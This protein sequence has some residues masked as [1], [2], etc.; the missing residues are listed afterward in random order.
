M[1][2]LALALVVAGGCSS[3][4][5]S[6]Q[7]APPFRP[8]LGWRTDLGEFRVHR[9]VALADGSLV[10]GATLHD[11]AYR[12]HP[13]W[14]P[15]DKQ[16]SGFEVI[17]PDGVVRR[18]FRIDGTSLVALG[19]VGERVV[20][21]VRRI[22]EVD[23]KTM[24]A[25]YTVSRV[26][27]DPIAGRAGAEQ[28]LLTTNDVADISI[29]P[30]GDGFAIVTS[31][32]GGKT[33]TV[34]RDAP[35]GKQRW[36]RTLDGEVTRVEDAG[37]GTLATFARSKTAIVTR[38]L[39]ARGADLRSYELGTPD[40]GGGY[41]A[42]FERAVRDDQELVMF[43][44]VGGG[45]ELAGKKLARAG[46]SAQPFALHTSAVAP[47]RFF[48]VNRGNGFVIGAGRWLGRTILALWI[49]ASP[50]DT[51]TLPW[52]IYLMAWD[53]EP[54]HREL[55][56]IYQYRHEDNDENKPL[57]VVSGAAIDVDDIVWTE[58]AAFVLGTCGHDGCVQQITDGTPSK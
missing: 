6:E 33:S 50:D 38:I 52:G 31:E 12:D 3:H 26:E 21:F 29:V 5:S 41:H 9:G 45:V 30:L 49:N 56:P 42:D 16:A 36:K 25:S 1:R 15:A 28:P 48:D 7:H 34:V 27:L 57:T 10:L 44:E 8:K 19:H 43:G 14:E 11:V 23:V 22:G 20:A 40:Q 55:F 24:T 46:H 47:T 53:P 13:V 54:A 32:L 39:D 35:D 17:G 2:T 51:P 18:S 37:D 58:H 4:G